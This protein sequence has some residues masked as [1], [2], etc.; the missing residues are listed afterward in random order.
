[1]TRLGLTRLEPDPSELVPLAERAGY[2]EVLRA[3]IG[4]LVGATVALRPSIA[5]VSAGLIVVVTAIYLAVAAIPMML[6]R[7]DQHRQL[8]A[9]VQWTLLVDGIYLAW[10]TLVTGGAVSPLRFLFFVHVIVVTL[11]VSYR[12][13]LKLAAWDSLL[14]LVVV[15][16]QAMRVP[17]AATT[18]ATLSVA[19]T[20][21]GLWMTAFATAAFSAVNERELRRQKADLSRLAD[22]TMAIDAADDDTEIAR[23][24]LDALV[25]SFGFARGAVLTAHGLD[26]NVVASTDGTPTALPLGSDELMERAWRTRQP[27]LS[28]TLDPA[29]DPRLSAL[30]PDARNVLVVPL[31]L[32]ARSRLGIVALEHPTVRGGMRQWEVSMVVQYAAHAALAMHNTWLTRE[33]ELQLAEIQ[34]LQA[35]LVAHNAQLE[36]TVASRTERLREAIVTLEKVDDQRRRLLSH[37]VRAQEDERTQIAN[38]IHDDP[39]QKLVAAKMQT[40]IVAHASADPHA[41][42]PVTAALKGCISSLRLLLFDLR[43]PI[44]DEQGVGP[45]IGY[46]LDRWQTTVAFAVRDDLGLEIPGDSRAIFFRIAHEALINARKYANASRLDVVLERQGDGF[47]MRISD[48]GVGFDP[49]EVAVTKPG[50][51]GLVAMRERA[52]MA[53]GTIDLHSLPGSGT[54]LEVW[55]P[56]ESTSVEPAPIERDDMWAVPLHRSA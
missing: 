35:E 40:E 2:A 55:M 39:L 11:L 50:H 42:D 47:L 22:V 6:R 10:V 26:L 53:G 33:R 38:D 9:V 44:L 15:R 36:Q 34:R 54:V 32:G 28:A 29:A 5:S 4:V 30:M 25:A 12:T 14:F 45:A 1:M 7:R 17:P 31:V 8:L 37:V 19:L 41:L 16:A 48:D 13:G 18:D 46:E 49:A 20:I 52:E 21:A 3:G 24:V 56:A 51:L 23:I 43:P 27:V